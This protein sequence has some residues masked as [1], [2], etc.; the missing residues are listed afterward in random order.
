MF[1]T[2]SAQLLGENRIFAQLYEWASRCT[3][4]GAAKLGRIAGTHGP[5][6]SPLAYFQAQELPA[7]WK[8]LV[9]CADDGVGDLQFENCRGLDA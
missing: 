7:H 4:R 2:A 6:L 5:A 9:A 1:V 3:S 8:P